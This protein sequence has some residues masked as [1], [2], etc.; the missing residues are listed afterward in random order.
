MTRAALEQ[1][2]PGLAEQRAGERANRARAF[3]GLTHT[4]CGVEVLALTPAHRLK[5]QLMR[6]AFTVPGAEPLAGDVFVFLWILTPA[7]AWT[8]PGRGIAWNWLQSRLRR[9]VRGL[10]LADAVRDVQTYLVGQLQD[11]P[12]SSGD[13]TDYSPWV[14]WMA[15]EASFWMNMH[16]GFTLE[17][18]QRTPY[19]VLQGMRRMWLVNHPNIT[20]NSKGE[21]EVEEPAFINQ[22]DR[23]VGAWQK[24]HSEAIATMIRSQRERLP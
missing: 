18:Y 3:A 16:G 6:N 9:H 21:L 24:Q 11:S 2:I 12:E 1:I 14:H 8:L 13:G 15:A 23:I 10:R 19:A 20:R 22:S 17:T 5:L 7:A 4:L